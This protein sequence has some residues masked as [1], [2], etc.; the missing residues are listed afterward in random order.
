MSNERSQLPQLVRIC[1]IVNDAQRHSEV[2][3]GRGQGLIIKDI[4]AV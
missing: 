3:D 1:A 2:E 4:R